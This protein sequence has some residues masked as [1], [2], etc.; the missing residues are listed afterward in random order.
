MGTRIDIQVG[1]ALLGQRVRDLAALN[2]EQ[3]IEREQRVREAST[4][5][6]ALDA[7][8][9]NAA[10]RGQAQNGQLRNSV[11]G[12]SLRP[13][14]YQ[15]RLRAQGKKSD[16]P[17]YYTA[18]RVAVTPPQSPGWL[19]AP[20]DIGFNARVKGLAPFQFTE[21]YLRYPTSQFSSHFT[22]F[23]VA[24][25]DGR[26]CLQTSTSPTGNP[27]YGTKQ[28]SCNL[29]A[30]TSIVTE[31]RAGFTFE[32]IVRLNVFSDS[33]ASE[34]A[35]YSQARAAALYD[36]C[37]ISFSYGWQ[38]TSMSPATYALMGRVSMDASGFGSSARYVAHG[39]FA[40]LRPSADVKPEL[41]D[42]ARWHH[43]AIVFRESSGGSNR[44]ARFYL[45]GQLVH[46]V[47]DLPAWLLSGWLA[48][49][50]SQP[51]ADASID[52]SY[53]DV[54]SAALES[55]SS[56]IHG[57]RFTSRALYTGASFTPPTSITSLA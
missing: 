20:F 31:P 49:Q 57:I 36:F 54:N 52:L 27:T 37:D 19:L 1:Q 17:E 42:G 44:E 56:S 43:A 39:G 11:I 18:P 5:Q 40:A 48:S 24:G 3:R 35:E 51:V 41:N 14:Q 23:S 10:Q 32:A 8:V 34:G 22:S 9:A 33:D 29:I 38:R 55:Q 46:Q 25:P 21:A 30:D 47:S 15:E 26:N 53:G 2:R 13:G 4:T 6:E 12:D 45:N 16:V 50:S 28:Y 7:G